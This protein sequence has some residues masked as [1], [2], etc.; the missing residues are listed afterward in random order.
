MMLDATERL[1]EVESRLAELA[2]QRR[3]IASQ[4]YEID[5]QIDKSSHERRMIEGDYRLVCTWET[6]DKW[7]YQKFGDYDDLLIILPI[8]IINMNQVLKPGEKWRRINEARYEASSAD[9][10]RT[11]AFFIEENSGP[12]NELHEKYLQKGE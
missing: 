4:L 7:W 12:I 2:E 9:K 11:A 5:R 10:S 3:P 6:N 1:A 8:L